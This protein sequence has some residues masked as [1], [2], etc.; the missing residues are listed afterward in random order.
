MPWNEATALARIKKHVA[1]APKFEVQRFEEYRQLYETREV[2]FAA[3]MESITPPL[4]SLPKNQAVVVDTVQIYIAITN[5]DEYRLEEGVETEASHDRAMRLLHLYYSTADR[6]IE[7]SSAQR[8]DFHS[9]RVHAVVLEQGNEGVTRETLAEAFAFI[10]DFQKV[11]VA[12]NRELGRSEF[13]ANFRIGVD[14]G[15]CVAI[16]N[17]T[18]DE[19]EPMFLGGAAN[20]AAKLAAGEESGVYVSD[21]V[22]KILG[23]AEEG[24]SLEFLSLSEGDVAVNSARRSPE[25]DLVF[26]EQSR[27]EFTDRIVA[28][29]RN[30]IYKGD[31]PDVT[32]ASF[33][34]FYQHPPLSEIDYAKLSPSHSIR[35]ALV[36]LFAD[37]SGYTNYVDDAVQKGAIRDV[38]RALFVI[39]QEFQNVVEDDFGGRKVRFIGDCIH[40]VIAEGSDTETNERNSV[41]TA[42]MC[43]GGLHKSFALCKSVLDD[44]DS[45]GLAVGLELGQT[46]ISR[47]GIRGDRSVRIASSVATTRSEQMQR[48]CEEN[49]VKIGPSALRVAPAALEDILDEAGYTAEPDYDEITVCLSAAPATV[50]NPTYARAHV[51]SSSEQP[52]AHLKFE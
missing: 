41:A 17:G 19:Q 26:G 34:F 24:V 51:P 10:E 23:H 35:M 43:A 3:A 2:A 6:V 47:I 33:S 37:L 21:R 12:A 49:R 38:V 1:E 50:A 40:A 28:N 22:R 30:E 11:A 13:D 7:N 14:V 32:D 31:L 18:G 39:R 42:T 46:P 29:W 8:V 16:N 45:L 52:R 48:E 36:S 27:E 44:L 15:T 9:G 25:G 20:H 4:F 5:Y